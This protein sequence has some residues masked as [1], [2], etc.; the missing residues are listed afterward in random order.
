MARTQT[1][2]VTK[3]FTVESPSGPFQFKGAELD[4]TPAVKGKK[5]TVLVD[6]YAEQAGNYY[7]TV[8]VDGQKVG[9]EEL[10]AIPADMNVN[11]RSDEFTVPDADSMTVTIRGGTQ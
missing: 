6:A 3:E 5:N 4:T 9:D 7:V 11:T 8:H 10:N 2:E 1:F